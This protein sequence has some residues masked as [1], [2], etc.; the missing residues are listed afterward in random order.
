MMS[1][2]YGGA[3]VLTVLPDHNLYVH[4]PS[5]R[6]AYIFTTQLHNI[7]VRRRNL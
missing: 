4:I 7:D 5:T 6:Y 1:G 3:T 2:C